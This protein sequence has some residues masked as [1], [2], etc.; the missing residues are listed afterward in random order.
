MTDKLREG[1]GSTSKSSHGHMKYCE[2]KW[3][4][5]EIWREGKNERDRLMEHIND[6]KKQ[7]NLDN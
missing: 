3:K 7:D 2:M 5:Q 6:K 4:T 1:Q